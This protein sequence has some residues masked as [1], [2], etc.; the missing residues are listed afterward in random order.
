MR[1]RKREKRRR[2]GKRTKRSEEEEEEEEEDERGLATTK[3]LWFRVHGVG[4]MVW[5][6]EPGNTVYCC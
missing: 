1:A 2:E 3:G 6:L 5:G 4:K